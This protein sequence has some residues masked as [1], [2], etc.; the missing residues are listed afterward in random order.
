MDTGNHNGNVGKHGAQDS[1]LDGLQVFEPKAKMSIAVRGGGHTIV[2]EWNYI[3][4]Y[5][6][7]Y[8]YNP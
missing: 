5:E 6:H 1:M 4:I 7:I 2:Y 8:I 3:Y